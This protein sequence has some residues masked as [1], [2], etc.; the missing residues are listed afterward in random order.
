MISI[1][2]KTL[3]TLWL[4]GLL[5]LLSACGGSSGSSQGDFLVDVDDE[6]DLGDLI[7]LG[8]S[9]SGYS[10]SGIIYVDRDSNIDA[11]VESESST[12]EQLNNA[13]NQAQEL[14]N[15]STVGGYLS[16]SSGE[17][18][19]TV[20]RQ[21]LAFNRDDQDFYEVA[22]LEGQRVSLAVFYADDLLNDIDVELFLRLKTSPAL[23][24]ESLRFTAQSVQSFVV[25]HTADYIIELRA[26]DA[27]FSDPVLYSLSISQYLVESAGAKST[28]DKGTTKS[29][30]V[31]IPQSLQDIREGE[32]V[33]RF[34]EAETASSQ[35]INFSSSPRYRA[36]KHGLSAKQVT[37]Q[38]H[39]LYRLDAETMSAALN[40]DANSSASIQS[41][42]LTRKLQ[43]W[44]RIQQL[45]QQDDV[46]LAEPNYIYRPSAGTTEPEYLRQ[47]NLPLLNLPAAWEIST[48]EN[49]TVAVIDTGIVEDHTDLTAN[50][51]VADG[52][53]FIQDLESAGDNDGMDADPNDEGESYHGNHVAGIIAADGRNDEGITGV[54]F[55][56]KIM[57]LRVIGINDEATTFDI[58]NAVLYAAN[59]SNISNRLPSEPADI[60]NLSL[61]GYGESS[62]LNLAIQEAISQGIIVVAAAGN[63]NTNDLFY[64]A[65]YEGVVGVGAVNDDLSRSSFSN[66]GSY[67]D[68]VAPGG[69]GFGDIRFD[70][71]QDGILSTVY[72]S[73]YIEYAGTSMAAPHVAGIAAL[74]KSFDDSVGHSAFQAA[75]SSGELTDDLGD[76]GYDTQSGFGLIN[77]AKALGAI[78]GGIPD[79]FNVN[80]ATI[81][82]IGANIS[83]TLTLSNSGDGGLQIVSVL[84]S[85]A[86]INV[87][88]PEVIANGF[89][90]T[91]SA[92]LNTLGANVGSGELTI[93]YRLAGGAEE[94]ETVQVFVSTT[95][96][97]DDTVGELTVFLL[98]QNNTTEVFDSVQA[99]A[100]GNGTY[101]YAF[102]EV[103]SGNYFLLA[104]TDHDYDRFLLDGGEARGAYPFFSRTEL[105]DLTSSNVSGA[106]FEVEFQ[107]LVQS[108][109]SSS[110]GIGVRQD[111]QPRSNPVVT[112]P[113]AKPVQ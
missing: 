41:D 81:G 9:N 112:Q 7:D 70:G 38:R 6:T 65:A 113:I 35:T 29:A 80:P 110:S 27:S 90:Y 37:G 100:N 103:P 5:V 20:F 22:L 63:N 45:K 77:A 85:Q 49:V 91:V 60:I 24:Q 33:V 18:P 16:G 30:A 50:L 97:N 59:Q 8:D 42:S 111:E 101:S 4:L 105:I 11:D 67:I 104:S 64:P 98:D 19:N 25:P 96:S 21:D 88:D 107:A 58:A 74:M 87:S 75:L 55:D 1:F 10:L 14:S 61:G 53:D 93:T 76:A 40:F 36:E 78:E 34:K 46:L 2:E 79:Q 94:V 54:A 108:S 43:T 95:S 12:F 3:S 47:W 32:V 84:P 23:S 109:F 92:D 89:R 99:T 62:F 13:I 102:T 57:P 83:T 44:Q 56:T 66:F 51:L 15:P 82:F 73:E 68:V 71:F 86:W 52:Y 69:T 39:G 31:S 28:G 26:R 17:Y 48:G 72:A 106:N